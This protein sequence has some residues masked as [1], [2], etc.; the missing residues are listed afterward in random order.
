MSLSLISLSINYGEGYTYLIGVRKIFT[1]HLPDARPG[2]ALAHM[3]PP[4][5][6]YFVFI[7]SPPSSLRL[8]TWGWLK[9]SGTVGCVLSCGFGGG[10]HERH[11]LCR[12][13]PQ[14]S[15]WSGRVL[16]PSCCGDRQPTTRVLGKQGGCTWNQGYGRRFSGKHRDYLGKWYRMKKIWFN[17]LESGLR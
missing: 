2:V 4:H 7:H 9:T 16:L 3:V 8:L 12:Q 14:R 10:V 11:T 5:Q 6:D 15:N 13:P 1:K 17:Y